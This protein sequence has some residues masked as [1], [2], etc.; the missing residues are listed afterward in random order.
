M[1]IAHGTFAKLDAS[2]STLVPLG[3]LL[4]ILKNTR[5]ICCSLTGAGFAPLSC[6]GVQVSFWRLKDQTK[7]PFDSQEVSTNALPGC[8]DD[9]GS[10]IG[11]SHCVL[12]VYLTEAMR[13]A[14]GITLRRACN[15]LP[16]CSTACH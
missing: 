12:L 5:S 2:P 13:I 3:D 11:A 9:V 14:F 16:V 10:I 15:A 4:G 7:L 8:L 1:K 6:Q